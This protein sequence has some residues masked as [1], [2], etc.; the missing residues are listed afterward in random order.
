MIKPTNPWTRE[1]IRTE[2]NTEI[3]I[4]RHWRGNRRQVVWTPGTTPIVTPLEG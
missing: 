2:G 1:S 4:E 3:R